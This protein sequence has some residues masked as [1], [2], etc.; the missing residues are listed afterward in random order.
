MAGL[1][2]GLRGALS[3]VDPDS[4]QPYAA[5]MPTFFRAVLYLPYASVPLLHVIDAH[6]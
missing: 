1:G 2:L 5:T 6:H 4:P 3:R